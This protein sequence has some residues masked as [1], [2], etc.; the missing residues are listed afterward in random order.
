[1]LDLEEGGGREGMRGGNREGR[2]KGGREG[3]RGGL[4]YLVLLDGI[5]GLVRNELGQALDPHGW[6][7]LD[8]W[9]AVLCVM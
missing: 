4:A 3:G 7:S 8:W 2:K 1:M 5:G 9:R 6:I